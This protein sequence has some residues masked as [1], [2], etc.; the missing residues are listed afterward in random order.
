[1]TA[2]DLPDHA[3]L[4]AWRDGDAIAG[5]L[6]VR[7]HFD[8]I[9]GFLRAKVPEHVDELV[10]RTFLGC[11]EAVDRI[12]EGLSFR[13]YLFGIARRQLIYHFRRSRREAARFDPMLESVLDAGGTPSRVVAM[14]QEERVVLDALNALP[15]DLQIILELH[16]WE[17][18]AVGEIGQVLEVP[19]GTVKSRLF[20]ARERLRELLGT[21]GGDDDATPDG[22]GAAPELRALQRSLLPGGGDPSPS[23]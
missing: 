14:R 13:A 11:T 4:R 23:G 20:R 9:F 21:P 10:Q 1:V 18:M 8:A 22:P 5:D 2:P 6:L 19:A 7:R 16:Y 12:D 15:L 17:G 3:L